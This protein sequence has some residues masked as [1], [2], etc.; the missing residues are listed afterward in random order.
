MSHL[1]V[2][3]LK[4]FAS[5]FL[6]LRNGIYIWNNTV[7]WKNNWS[8]WNIW[9]YKY[10]VDIIEIKTF[11]PTIN[12]DFL[13]LLSMVTAWV[14]QEQVTMIQPMDINHQT[15][16]MVNCSFMGSAAT[17]EQ[18]SDNLSTRRY[19]AINYQRHNEFFNTSRKMF[20][21]LRLIEFPQLDWITI[22][23]IMSV[24]KWSWIFQHFSY[25]M[26]ARK[27]DRY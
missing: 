11:Y 26:H 27:A 5:H 21:I 16:R 18:A 10:D 6:G 7:M 2:I 8:N 24:N 19:L 17:P 9:I 25:V 20:T 1:I 23:F 4:K 15:R 14:T 13:H 22:Y 3:T 12:Q